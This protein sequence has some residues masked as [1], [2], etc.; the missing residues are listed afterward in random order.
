MSRLRQ[1]KLADNLKKLIKSICYKGADPQSLTKNQRISILYNSY[2]SSLLDKRV[3]GHSQGQSGKMVIKEA[4]RDFQII[5]RLP[6]ENRTSQALFQKYE[7]LIAN[8]Y[9][10]NQSVDNNQLSKAFKPDQPFGSPEI[11][12]GRINTIEDNQK[13]QEHVGREK[14][15]IP[16]YNQARF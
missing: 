6:S 7:T 8:K 12:H 9:L 16:K 4:K 1:L 15:G 10:V 11:V 2:V 13:V 3:S 14:E 5:V